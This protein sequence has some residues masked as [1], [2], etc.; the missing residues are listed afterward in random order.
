[1]ADD[2]EK[3][4]RRALV[5]GATGLVG[6]RCL[7]H[8]ASRDEYARVVCLVRR[9]KAIRPPATSAGGPAI[10]EHVVDFAALEAKDIEE[11]DD[12]YCAIG[13]TMKKAG[14][15]EAF[16]CVDFEIPLAVAKL[17][18]AKGARR[19]ALVSSIGA[20]ASSGNFYLKTKGELEDALAALFEEHGGKALHILR[21]SFLVPHASADRSEARP[22]EKL[23]IAVAVA[24]RGLMMGGLRKYRPI[25]VDVVGS[26]M[27]TAT[28]G[29]DPTP[30]K[31]TY[32]HD[33]IN[34][35]AGV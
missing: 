24:T 34:V 7:H 25:N 20:D 22:G 35:L 33:Q 3:K 16:R 28:L 27:V 1:M 13:S 19:L 23:G 17:A 14:S 10:D 12:I 15:K 18:F 6:A 2:P 4:K 21:P 30:F 32:D 5:L 26:A 9:A 8:L 29:P 11:V 31:K